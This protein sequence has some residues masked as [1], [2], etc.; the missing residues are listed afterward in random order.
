MNYPENLKKG[1]TIGICAPSGG[2]SKQEK[3]QELEKAIQQLEEMGYKIIETESV[4]KE[5]KGRSNTAEQ[6]AKEFMELLE[7]EE[8]KDRKSVV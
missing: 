2:I 1:D 3:I 4:R 5:E 8:V 7:N 6:R